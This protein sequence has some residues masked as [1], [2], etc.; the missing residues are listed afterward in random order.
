MYKL[1][2]TAVGC[3]EASTAAQIEA[4]IHLSVSLTR[5]NTANAAAATASS[6][7][8][9]MNNINNISG[10]NNSHNASWGATTESGMDS[11]SASVS[12]K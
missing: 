8:G 1:V 7:S 4:E 12:S 9:N 10:A 2:C 5:R 6:S 3:P 11:N